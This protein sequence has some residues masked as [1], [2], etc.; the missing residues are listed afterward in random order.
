MSDHMKTDAFKDH[1]SGHASAYADAR[2]HYPPELFTWLAMLSPQHELAWDCG[3]GNGQAAVALTA[4]YRR[5]IATDASAQQIKLAFQHP[6]V[7]YRTAPAEHSGLAAHSVDLVTVAQ[8]AHWFDLP[9]FYAEVR[10]VVKPG[11][12]V[13]LWCYGLC[14]IA[15]EVDAVVNRFYAGETDAYWPPERRLVDASYRTL[16]FAFPEIGAPSMHMRQIWNLAQFLAYLSTWSG[17]QRFIKQ[18]G[19]DPIPALASELSGVWDVPEEV[20]DVVWPLYFRVGQVTG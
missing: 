3:T 14:R 6:Q 15:P 19:R 11:G 17:V 5:V 7:E 13:V 4:H 12:A 2:P 9:A 8:A 16:P 1:F 20:R 10:R 18:T